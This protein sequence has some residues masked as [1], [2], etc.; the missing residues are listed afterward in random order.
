M[1]FPLIFAYHVGDIDIK[2]E[3]WNHVGAVFAGFLLFFHSAV[4]V[5]VVNMN[6]ANMIVDGISGIIDNKASELLKDKTVSIV[7]FCVIIGFSR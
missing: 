7:P 5:T 6:A 1:A 2:I 3:L 4:A